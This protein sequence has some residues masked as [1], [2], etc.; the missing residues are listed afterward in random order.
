MK[1]EKHILLITPGFP[2]DEND[3]H[4][5]PPLQDYLIGFKVKYPETKFSVIALHYPHKSK[6]YKWNE[7]QV[8]S[9]GGRNSIIKKPFI[10]RNA[11]RQAKLINSA[12]AVTAIHSLWFGECAL[13]GNFISKK[14]NC[15]HICTL[16]GQDV[17]SSNK[18]LKYLKNKKIKIV[19]LSKNQ[20]IQL[21]KLLNK[22]ADEIIHW[23][24]DEQSGSKSKRD[25]DLLAVGAL[26]PLKNYSLLIRMIEEVIPENPQ[27]KAMLVG[28]GS[29]DSKL[30]QMIY[31][32]KLEKNIEL[33]GVLNRTEIFKL[34]RRSR[35][36]VHPSKFEGSGF[37]LIC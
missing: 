1:I 27:L 10:W 9:L 22:N 23:G 31:E 14:I 36:F 19:A 30:K 7:I 26:I 6:N 12:C 17:K 34:M 37:V 24:I 4:C 21:Y 5:I 11:I 8:T 35:I 33:T 28:S 13:I 16:M 18:Y 15:N 32:K 29:E 25:I 2:E 20:D 3:F